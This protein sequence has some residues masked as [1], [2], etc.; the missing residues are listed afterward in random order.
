MEAVGDMEADMEAVPDMAVV[1][2]EAGM[3][4]ATDTFPGSDCL[5]ITH[6]SAAKPGNLARV[7]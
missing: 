1:D 3:A 6:I 2:M 7:I 5:V 4:A